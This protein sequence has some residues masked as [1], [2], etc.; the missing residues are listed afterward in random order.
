MYTWL[1]FDDLYQTLTKQVLS[2][3]LVGIISDVLKQKT[4][5]IIHSLKLKSLPHLSSDV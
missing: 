2:V 1:T 4:G 3:V 5:A